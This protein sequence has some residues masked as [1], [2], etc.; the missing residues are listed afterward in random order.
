MPDHIHIC[1]D[2]HLPG[3]D[4]RKGSVLR[5][6]RL[7]LGYDWRWTIGWSFR[8]SLGV[9]VHVGDDEDFAGLSFQPGFG[10]FYLT[11]SPPW[12]FRPVKKN[13]E[14][15]LSVHDWAAWWNLGLDPMDAQ[16]GWRYDCFHLDPREWGIWW[17]ARKWIGKK[18][19]TEERVAFSRVVD[20]ALPEGI[21]PCRFD[22]METI[23]HEWPFSRTQRRWHVTPSKPLPVPGKGE[24][25][26]DCDDDAIHS[27]SLG[28]DCTTLHDAV[29]RVI[30]SVYRDRLKYGGSERMGGSNA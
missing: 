28:T 19:R 27:M 26:W 7:F 2:N 24:N 10:Y 25:S 6:G 30:A 8:R 21:T 17:R 4:A 20:V 5:H 14:L 22:W 12:K 16:L 1:N 15:S 13:H 29:G 9:S 11:F 23:Y 18:Y 3:P